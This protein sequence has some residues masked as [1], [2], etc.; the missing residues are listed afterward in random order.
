MPCSNKVLHFLN[1]AAASMELHIVWLIRFL[2][3]VVLTLCQIN[4][5]TEPRIYPKW[6][7]DQNVKSAGVASMK[8]GI[9]AAKKAIN[10]LH[11]ELGKTGFEQVVHLFSL[12]LCLYYYYNHFTALWI[13]SGATW[14]SWYQKKHSPT[15]TYHGHQSFLICFLHLL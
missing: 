13:L 11:D 6:S 10:A 15:H 9:T 8:S 1:T 5:V 3:V 7:S 12:L 2:V 14:V 4:V